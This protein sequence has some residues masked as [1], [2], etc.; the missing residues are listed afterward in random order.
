MSKQQILKRLKAI[1]LAITNKKYNRE[2]IVAEWLSMVRQMVCHS[3]VQEQLEALPYEV[4]FR[5]FAENEEFRTLI[6]NILQEEN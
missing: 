1:E 4:N 2:E 6:K 5:T 3:D